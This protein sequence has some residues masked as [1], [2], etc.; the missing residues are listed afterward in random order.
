MHLLST[1][2]GSSVEF[3]ST[4]L[5]VLLGPLKVKINLEQAMQ[6]QRGSRGMAL[7]KITNCIMTLVIE[8]NIYVAVKHFQVKY[9]Y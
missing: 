5:S 1:L 8:T 2:I 3:N 6:A 7:R 4:A 9:F